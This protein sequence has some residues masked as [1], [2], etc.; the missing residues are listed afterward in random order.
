MKITQQ[1]LQEQ[2]DM[3]LM[4]F[5]QDSIKAPMRSRYNRL[6]NSYSTTKNDVTKVCIANIKALNML[7][8]S[9]GLQPVHDFEDDSPAVIPGKATK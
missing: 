9:K 2:Y 5:Y 7:A 8:E 3:L 1:W 6:T 4:Q